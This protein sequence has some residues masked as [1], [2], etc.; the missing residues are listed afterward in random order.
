MLRKTLNEEG[1]EYLTEPYKNSMKGSG[2]KCIEAEA[3]S[4]ARKVE[5]T[6]ILGME[7]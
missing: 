5:V 6:T 2:S 1:D 4:W 7:A 3:S